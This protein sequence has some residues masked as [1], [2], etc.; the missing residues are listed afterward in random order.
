MAN[1]SK[2]SLSK[3]VDVRVAVR[4]GKEYNKLCLEKNAKIRYI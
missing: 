4:R 1:I 3:I 2:R